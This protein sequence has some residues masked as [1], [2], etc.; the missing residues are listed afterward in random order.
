[1]FTATMTTHSG[2]RMTTISSASKNRF[3]VP[4]VSGEDGI[5]SPS[6]ADTQSQDRWTT[7]ALQVVWTRAEP[8]GADELLLNL[9]GISPDS[10]ADV[11]GNQL[12]GE[13]TD[14][15]SNYPSGDGIAG[16][17]FEFRLNVLPGNVD[18][19]DGVDSNDE[20]AVR[21]SFGTLV[22]YPRTQSSMISM[23]TALFSRTMCCRLGV[24]TALH[25]RSMDPSRN[26]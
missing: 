22:D 9:D 14:A 20:Q 3:C 21:S 7:T 18:Q 1:M 17:D 15:I 24:K 26:P 6:S 23:A 10:V 16:G 4:L 13:W 5:G 11:A 12:D 25:C 2:T 8:V 19:I